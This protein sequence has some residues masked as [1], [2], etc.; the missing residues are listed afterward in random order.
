MS[1][2]DHLRD[3]PAARP[4]PADAHRAA[5]VA[6]ALLIAGSAAALV[7][8]AQPWWRARGDGVDVGIAGTAATGG[9]CQALAIVAAAGTA[10]LLV[11]GRR[12]RRIV[13]V[14]LAL[15]GGAATSLGAAHPRPAPGLVRTEVRA[16]SLADQFAVTATA[17]PWFYAA[18]GV[19]IAAGGVVVV[20]TAHRWRGRGSRFQAGASYA[21]ANPEIETRDLDSADPG[22]LWRAMDA[23]GDPT[24]DE[25]I[26]SGSGP[27]SAD[28]A[29]RQNGTTAE[30]PPDVPNGA[31][32]DTMG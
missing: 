25:P 5:T 3:A 32:H 9:L 24:D 6:A 4:R 10:L 27:S 19:A 30:S 28:Q 2:A 14:L 12:G 17:W 21:P 20:R 18:A 16:V 22:A 31:T 26:G 8:G 11:L 15:A 7:A 29:P 1:G 13:G 23:G